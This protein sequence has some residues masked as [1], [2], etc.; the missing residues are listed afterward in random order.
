MKSTAN[1]H[2]TG[3]RSP[4]CAPASAFPECI[5]RMAE[6]TLLIFWQQVVLVKFGISKQRDKLFE[7]FAHCFTV[8]VPSGGGNSGIPVYQIKSLMITC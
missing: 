3:P 2:N 6:R 8:G 4:V 5:V 1:K 7:G